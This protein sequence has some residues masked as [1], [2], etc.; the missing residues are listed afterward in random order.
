MALPSPAFLRSLT[1]EDRPYQ[2]AESLTGAGALC[3]EAGHIDSRIL[4]ACGEPGICEPR[5]LLLSTNGPP[6]GVTGLAKNEQAHENFCGEVKCGLLGKATL[7]VN[8]F[9][10]TPVHLTNT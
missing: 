3:R 10:A 2:Y 9:S 6:W 7:Y 1:R 4:R 8:Q 5:E